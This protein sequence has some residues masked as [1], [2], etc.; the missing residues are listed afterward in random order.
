MTDMNTVS[1]FYR[2][3]EILEE[4]KKW[5]SPFVYHLTNDSKVS[6]LFHS[7]IRGFLIEEEERKLSREI[8]LLL[9]CGVFCTKNFVDMLTKELTELKDTIKMDFDL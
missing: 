9:Q 8:I 5:R 7:D 2:K 4:F 6:I 1:E 3:R